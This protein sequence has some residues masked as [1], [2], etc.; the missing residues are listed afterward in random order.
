L[1]ALTHTSPLATSLLP[2]IT[3]ALTKNEA[4]FFR[5]MSIP[6]MTEAM[7]KSLDTTNTPRVPRDMKAYSP[8]SIHR[9]ILEIIALQKEV[10]THPKQ[11]PIHE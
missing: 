5:P 2:S 11:A 7:K 10:I 4:E 3:H 6:D 8:D 1:T 9:Q